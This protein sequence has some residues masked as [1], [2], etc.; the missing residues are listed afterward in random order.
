M[1]PKVVQGPIWLAGILAVTLQT[2]KQKPVHPKQKS[3]L[4]VEQYAGIRLHCGSGSLNYME[5]T[6]S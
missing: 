5:T 2:D 4:T 3:E 1:I 6:Y